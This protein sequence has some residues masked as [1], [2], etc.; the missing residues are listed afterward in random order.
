MLVSFLELLEGIYDENM[1]TK[2]AFLFVQDQS[3]A[4]KFQSMNKFLKKLLI[5]KS[6]KEQTYFQNPFWKA[7]P[8]I[9]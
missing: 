8:R 3:R 9:L 7:G 1:W 6:L 4:G 2:I 5:L